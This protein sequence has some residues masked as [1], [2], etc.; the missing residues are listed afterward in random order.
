MKRV[1]VILLL[2][3]SSL[4]ARGGKVTWEPIQ[5]KVIH[6]EHFDIHFPA[7]YESLG[8]IAMGYAE[9]A[10]IVLSKRLNHNLT[11]VVPIYIYPSHTHFQSTNIIYSHIDE[12]IGG[13]T[14]PIKKR[15]AIPFLGSYD[16]FR[17][18][19]T[20][21]L[22]H[23]FQFDILLN[24]SAGSVFGVPS[25]NRAPLWLIEGSAEYFSLGW[26]PM[27]EMVM[28]DAVLKGWT[29]TL[30]DMTNGRVM[31]QFIFYKGGQAVV[32]FL[33]ETY[34][35]AKIGE[36]LRDIRDQKSFNDA[37]KTN[38]GMSLEELDRLWLLWV[39]RKYFP[40][41]T[42]KS[43][44]EESKVL[45][46]HFE[47]RSWLN[48]HPAISPDGKKVVYITIRK[49]EEVI[50]IRDANAAA[51]KAD[52]SIQ[53]NIFGKPKDQSD[54][55]PSKEKIL[56][57]A[58]DNA[59][60]YQLHLL[61]NRITF[62][63]DSKNI[64][65]CARSQGKDRLYLFNLEK[66]KIVKSWTPEADMIQ[67]PSLS[68]D[69]KKAVFLGTIRAVPDIFILDL[70][71]SK[72]RRLTNN[73]FT[74]KD[75]RLT[76][77][78]KTLIYSSNE[79][80]EGIFESRDYNIFSYDMESTEKKVIIE[81]EGVQRN[82]RFTGK[83]DNKV[84]FISNHT[85]VPNAYLYDRTDN[86]IQELTDTQG[87]I[88]NVD[89]DQTGHKIVFALYRSMGYDVGIREEN[90]AENDYPEIGF[91]KMIFPDTVFP[92]YSLNLDSFKVEKAS[93]KFSPDFMFFGLQ[94]SNNSQFGGFIYSVFS[95]Y[96]GDHVVEVYAD[97]FNP[98]VSPNLNIEYAYKKNR[99]NW[100]AGAYK[101]NNYFSI[102]NYLDLTSINDFLYN[103]YGYSLSLMKVGGYAMGSYPITPF[104]SANVGAEVSRYDETFYPN[105]KEKFARKDIHTDL[106]SLQASIL[107]NNVL[108]S[109]FGP[110]KG[111]HAALSV[112]QTFDFSGSDYVFNRVQADVRKYFLFFERYV[113]TV[114]VMGGV[115]TGNEKDY[116]PWLIGGYNTIRGYNF[117]S[118]QG[119]NFFM[120]NLELRFPFLDYLVFGF[121]GPWAIR[122]FSG[123]LFLDM[124]SAYDSAKG[125]KMVNSKTGALQDL[126]M[127]LGFGIR[128]VLMPGILLKIDWATPW[129]LQK[130][131]PLSKWQGV[132]SIG[133][134]F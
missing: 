104:L 17:H 7:N 33:A 36:L 83:D 70:E 112:E 121:P 122:G 77:D 56:L 4:N 34:G 44:L 58:G 29:P 11:E 16:E 132:F 131:R 15:V 101:S 14:E 84:L 108:Y 71:T 125:W 39:K 31:S 38:F 41:I 2:T 9:Q 46:R 67:Y 26:D 23:S 114:R 100:S 24:S 27:A 86:R 98:K 45:T 103:P 30:V 63:P 19:I 90:F 55:K 47:D 48:L 92:A 68:P 129:D 42:K 57:H 127:S 107:F 53:S 18:V 75:P 99:M 40:Y 35:E 95:D 62:T 128:M 133:Y 106:Y 12:G 120:T 76:Q 69:G 116:F 49:Y 59:R 50:V 79:N 123:V 60:V 74:E 130:I 28:R 96:L 81:L 64:F 134:E 89:I 87:G 1:F 94:W 10:N 126:K 109:Y 21:E 82:P 37:I 85:G 110:L 102:L 65:F 80:E 124:G 97:Y 66:R 54:D 25:G 51:K 105:L 13:F 22:V 115:V 91:E 61:D 113:F 118:M 5:W 72:T 93:I 73:K 3:A 88:T 111:W 20:H 78:N 119:D 52:Y 117:I 43:E 32:R 8:E 6:S